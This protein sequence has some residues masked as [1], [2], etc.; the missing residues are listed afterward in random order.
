MINICYIQWYVITYSYLIQIMCP[1]LYGF[2]RKRDLVGYL[3]GFSFVC[4]EYFVLAY[5]NPFVF[6]L[7]HLIRWR[8]LCLWRLQKNYWRKEEETK[9]PFKFHSYFWDSYSISVAKRSS[10]WAIRE[11]SSDPNKALKC[12]SR[13]RWV[14]SLKSMFLSV[15]IN[16]VGVFN[17]SCCLRRHGHM[18][19]TRLRRIRTLLAW[20][21][22]KVGPSCIKGKSE[23]R[24]GLFLALVSLDFQA[25]AIST[26]CQRL[27][28][29]VAFWIYS[30]LFLFIHFLFFFF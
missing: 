28:G 15:L 30:I 9:I 21:R 26:S 17:T 20:S 27:L 23:V 11:Q 25:C 19:S 10:F 7:P 6:F 2:M 1:Q 16:P 13:F 3:F 12:T 29:T 5:L 8:F 4:C 18:R 14:M 24:T 22:E